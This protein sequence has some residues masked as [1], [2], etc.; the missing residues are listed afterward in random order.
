MKR[1][2]II[3]LFTAFSTL[4]G[5]FDKKV[6]FIWSHPNPSDV[7]GY[8]L[9]FGAVSNAVDYAVHVGNTNKVTLTVTNVPVFVTVTAY[10]TNGFESPPSNQLRLSTPGAPT[11]LQGISVRT[12]ITITNIVE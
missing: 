8:Y 3:A 12:I 1:L 4:G 6:T 7:E 2:T 5:N 9:N 10:N 11:G